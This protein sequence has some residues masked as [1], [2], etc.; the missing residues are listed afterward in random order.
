MER[1]LGS[2]AA[3]ETLEL[4]LNGSSPLENKVWI[5]ALETGISVKHE[6][7]P[8][9]KCPAKMIEDGAKVTP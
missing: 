7:I 3:S 6:I 8:T 2:V 5:T 9:Y 4:I 1:L